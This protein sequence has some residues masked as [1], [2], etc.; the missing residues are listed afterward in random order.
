M[1]V[2]LCVEETV[3]RVAKSVGCTSKTGKSGVRNSYLITRAGS[4]KLFFSIINLEL[5][6]CKEN[7]DC[8]SKSFTPHFKILQSFYIFFNSS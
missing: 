8:I 6:A 5:L 1:T 2:V 4:V 3:Q 7:C